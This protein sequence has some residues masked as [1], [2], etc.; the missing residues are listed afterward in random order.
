MTAAKITAKTAVK[1]AARPAAAKC[2][3]PLS[4]K[5]VRVLTTEERI[6]DMRA[7]GKEVRQSKESAVAFLQRAGILDE[8]GELAE[9]FRG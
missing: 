6:A 1:A 5:F 4:G 8:T 3:A 9:P 2:A 7:F